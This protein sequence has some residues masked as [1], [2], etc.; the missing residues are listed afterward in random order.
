MELPPLFAGISPDAGR[1]VTALLRP[2]SFGAGETLFRQGERADSAYFVVEGDVG[3]DVRLPGGAVSA[4][5]T[6]GAGDVLGELALLSEGHRRTATATA[7]GDV[8]CMVMERRD[9]LAL[10]AQYHP[11]SPQVLGK[12][13]DHV[14][15]RLTRVTAERVALCGAP[16]ALGFPARAVAPGS[17]FPVVPHAPTLAFTAA[18]NRDEV[19]QLFAAGDLVTVPART[20]IAPCADG[21][22]W[23]L[24]LRGAVS[25]C[26]A[27]GGV[28]RR[29]S[30]VGPGRVA[31]SD[32]FTPT[33]YIGSREG[34]TLLALSNATVLGWRCSGARWMHR[35]L[36]AYVRDLMTRL[37][38]DTRSLARERR[39]VFGFH[40]PSVV[41]AEENLDG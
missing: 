8:R 15:A 23:W 7:T 22:T 2:L 30:L 21:K 10:C 25:A 41:T 32:A 4:L 39:Q 38:E 16:R 28:G 36:E 6:L 24:V 35:A 34:A 12:L 17:R 18:F 11:A 13:A 40:S 26:F 33:G 1:I 19:E 5:T 29:L 37:A 27:A 31:V 3:I 20:A 9:L 14:M